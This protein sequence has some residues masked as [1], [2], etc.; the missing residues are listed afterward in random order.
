MQRRAFDQFQHQRPRVTALF[1]AVDLR[2]VGVV[3][4]RQHLGF[5]LEPGEA[6]WV[7]GKSVREDFQRHVPIE[8]RIGCPIHDA[9]PAFTQT[10]RDLEDAEATAYF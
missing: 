4:G 1:E 5:P 8:R 9:H 2:D 3:Q 10:A 7:G 6:F